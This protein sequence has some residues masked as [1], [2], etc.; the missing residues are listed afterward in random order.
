MAVFFQPKLCSF[1]YKVNHSILLIIM[2]ANLEIEN[3]FK[4]EF[5]T[6]YLTI[7]QKL[8]QVKAFIFDWDGVFND[9][10]KN[11]NGHSGFS[12]IDSMG[13]NL[14]RF[15]YYLLNKQTPLTAIVT[16][17]NNELAFSYAKREHLSSVYYK[18][19][20][21]EKALMHFCKENAISPTDVLFV[22]DDVLDLSA[23]KF[24]GVRMMVGRSSNPLL[25][26]YAVNNRLVDYVTANDGS[27]YAMREVCEL[28][29]ALS[30]NYN[31]VIE[32]RIKFSDIY[33]SYLTE[34]NEGNTSLFTSA[35][36]EIITG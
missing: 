4:G 36:T 6:N 14:M 5:I 16:G 35:Q 27:N 26:E 17:E 25:T 2:Q 18:I 29:M 13:I 19:A 10:Q 20:N 22:F 34:R 9:G 23:A 28:V 3:Y 33:S 24:A 8:R 15:S 12:E 11:I 30:N 32:N 7:K 21:K 1:K 31:S